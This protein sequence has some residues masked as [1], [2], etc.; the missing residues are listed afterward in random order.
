MWI[1][2]IYNVDP[3]VCPRC[4]EQMKI[5]AFIHNSREIT[6][7]TASIGLQPWRAPPPLSNLRHASEPSLVP[8]FE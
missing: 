4:G 6:K 1:K 3:L 8:F 5:I 2:K 7:I